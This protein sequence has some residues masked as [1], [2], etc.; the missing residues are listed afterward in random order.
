MGAVLGVG[1]LAALA[2]LAA[3]ALA[4][5][6]I[7]AS[8]RKKR[9]QPPPSPDAVVGYI[10]RLNATHF[11]VALQ[12]PAMMHV[13]AYRVTAGGAYTPAPEA[14]LQITLPPAAQCLQ[15]APASGQ[16]TLQCQ[17]ALNQPPTIKEVGLVVTG[18]AGGKQVQQPVTVELRMDLE[19]EFF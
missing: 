5:A 13:A 4:I 17:L 15:V 18:T 3:A 10:L 16:G 1:A 9:A 11:A 2:A 19:L 6:A 7:A 14:W 12:Q 8:R